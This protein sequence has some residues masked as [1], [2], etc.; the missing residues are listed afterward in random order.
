M[1]SALFLFCFHPRMI[2]SITLPDESRRSSI[3][4]RDASVT[5]HQAVLQVSPKD[6]VKM[7]P[8]QLADHQIR[9][10]NIACSITI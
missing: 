4:S 10:Y 5:D 2:V 9:L 6:Y 3:W 8:E 1:Y 7:L